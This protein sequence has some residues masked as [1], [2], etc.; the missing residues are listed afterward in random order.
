[1]NAAGLD[2]LIYRSYGYA[3]HC[4]RPFRRD[5]QSFVTA[6]GAPR[7]REGTAIADSVNH[8]FNLDRDFSAFPFHSIFGG[9]KGLLARGPDR[10]L[11]W[12]RSRPSPPGYLSPWSG[13]EIRGCIAEKSL[14]ISRKI[15]QEFSVRL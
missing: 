7:S 13:E 14:E 15:L 11:K 2:A 1:M 9:V 3:C 12:A 10:D 8:F 4:R 6:R 5:H